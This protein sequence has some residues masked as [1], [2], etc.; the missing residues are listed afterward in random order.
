MRRIGG[1]PSYNMEASV[2][3][4]MVFRRLYQE[5]VE[6]EPLQMAEY[7]ADLS[8][9]AFLFTA[10]NR[11][12][13]SVHLMPYETFQIALGERIVQIE[14]SQSQVNQV[15]IFFISDARP[16]QFAGALAAT[17]GK[18]MT[19][20]IKLDLLHIFNT[21]ELFSALLS[22]QYFRIP[23]IYSVG[24]LTHN[25]RPRRE[26]QALGLPL[27]HQCSL[28]GEY[29]FP[30]QVCATEAAYIIDECAGTFPHCWSEFYAA[31]PGKV[32]RGRP[33]VDIAFWEPTTHCELSRRERKRV[34]L[35]SQSVGSEI[36][37]TGD[38]PLEFLQGLL[39]RNSVYLP[40]GSQP[41]L[42]RKLLQGADYYLFDQEIGE[43]KLLLGAMAAG[44]IAVAR[45]EGYVQQVIFTERDC[46]EGVTGYS[47][48]ADQEA[49]AGV[50][51]V[52]VWE[53]KERPNW[54]QDIRVRASQLI[55]YQHC[56]PQAARL[57]QCI[58][59]GFAPV[60][61]PFLMEYSGLP[62]AGLIN[63]GMHHER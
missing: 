47:Y 43:T 59:E 20:E 33:A 11:L 8:G 35:A 30:E 21:D 54:Q 56:L 41:S 4:G 38:L 28:L 46:P 45:N 24:R 14:V 19:E 39:P 57:Y 10:D 1:N 5:Y 25:K 52:A 55:H 7:V 18:L 62:P 44:C 6:S 22:K 37:I 32:V 36:L 3:I 61:L 16:Q 13:Q 15:R 50:L 60:K 48:D 42:Q 17:I 49:L 51:E 12:I 34:L 31:Y 29:F 26:L 27:P 23:Y 9:Q 2:N 40:L 53:S 58:Y 63:G